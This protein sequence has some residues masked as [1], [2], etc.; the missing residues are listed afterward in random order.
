M[1]CPEIKIYDL[2]SPLLLSVLDISTGHITQKDTELLEQNDCPVSGYPYGPKD[3]A[4][5]HLVHL[6]NSPGDFEIEMSSAK[7]YGFSDA[8]I[9]VCKVARAKSCDYV[10]FDR[11]GAV[12][13]LPTFDW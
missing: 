2:E 13:D 3:D 9:K 4:Y 5:G 11:D 12:Y 10:R 6:T 1:N 7:K 8:F